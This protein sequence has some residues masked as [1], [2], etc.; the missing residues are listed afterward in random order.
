M[1]IVRHVAFK[2]IK[3][4]AN[5]LKASKLNI[6]KN[7]KLEAQKYTNDTWGVQNHAQV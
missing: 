2:Y 6:K 5:W 3:C 1:I 7:F 4:N